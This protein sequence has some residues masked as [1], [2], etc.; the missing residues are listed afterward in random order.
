MTPFDKSAVKVLAFDLFGT[1]F[2]VAD[3]PREEL[4]AYGDTIRAPEWQPFI[5]PKSW[6]TMP[7][8]PD[9]KFG[10][11]AL[12]AYGYYTVALSNA[13]LALAMRMIAHA[14][15]AFN[16]IIPLELIE[17]YKPN[18][19]CY[20]YAQNLCG[21]ERHEF[22]MISANKSFGDIEAALGL[23]MGA[24]LIRNPGMPA[25]IL[26]LVRLLQR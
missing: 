18:P 21:V 7:A 3:V 9:S 5:W 19:A 1:V 22:V 13:P 20:T 14:D 4:R 23:G 15:L 6:E 11:R 12:Q 8:F 2:D 17:T 24:Q 25:T 16:A 10:L 26:D